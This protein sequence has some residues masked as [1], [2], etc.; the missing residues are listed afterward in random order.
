MTAVTAEALARG[1]LAGPAARPEDAIPGEGRRIRCGD[2]DQSVLD[3]EYAGDDL[4][5][6]S[7]PTPDQKAGRS[8]VGL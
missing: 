5:G 1:S 6:G 7:S 4:P 8:H 2:P 3:N